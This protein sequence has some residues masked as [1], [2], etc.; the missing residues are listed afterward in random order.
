MRYT[1]TC[2]ICQQDKVEKVKVYELL[3]PLPVSTR[4]WDN[5]SMDFITH[6]LKV[7]NI[8]AILVIITQISKYVTFIPTTKLCYAEL[9]AQLFFKHVVK[10]WEVP[11]SIVS[12]RDNR[13]IGTF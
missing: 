12:D 9:T 5:V 4:P 13:F 1:K 11:T 8:E 6:L 2:L 3:E 10:L 7:G